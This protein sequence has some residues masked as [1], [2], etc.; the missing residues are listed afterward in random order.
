MPSKHFA[1]EKNGGSDSITVQ[2]IRGDHGSGLTLSRGLVLDMAWNR[3]EEL[4]LTIMHVMAVLYGVEVIKASLSV[5]AVR[6]LSCSLI[7]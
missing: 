2:N 7:V 3:C 4:L 6:F 5:A 1:Q